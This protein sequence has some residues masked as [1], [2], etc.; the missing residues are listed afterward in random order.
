[1]PGPGKF[2]SK[3]VKQ[4]AVSGDHSPEQCSHKLNGEF[5]HFKPDKATD[6]KEKVIAIELLGTRELLVPKREPIDRP[7]ILPLSEFQR[8]KHQA[9]VITLE[10]KMRMIEEGEREKNKLVMESTLRKEQLLKT[11]KH[12]N[13]KPGSK[14]ETVESEAAKKNL[15]LLRRSQ[16]LR[17]EQDERVKEANGIILATKCRAIRNAQIAEKKVIEKELKEEEQRLDAMMEQQRQKKIVAEEKKREADEMKKQNYVKEVLQ[18]IKENELDRLLEAE[19]IEEESKM[20][21]KALIELQKDE[22]K[23]QKAKIE[24]QIKMREEFKKANEE[25]CRY[26]RLKAEEQRIADLRVKEFMRQKAER[27]EALEKEKSLLKAAKEKEIARLREMQEKSQDLQ[28]ALDEMNAARS[29]EEKEREW[30]EQEKQAALK[31][32]KMMEDLH[33]ARAKQITDIRMTQARALARD[34]DDFKK[35]AKVQHELHLKDLEKQAKKREEIARHRK[36]LLKQINEKERERINWQQ[37]RYDDGKAQRLDFVLKDK[38][39]EE[40]LKH[41]IEKLRKNNVPDN[42][43]KDIERQLRL[44]GK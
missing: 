34:E 33:V 13:N 24:M 29:Q 9:H 39:V 4:K 10:D 38:N 11:Q 20:L 18:Q 32:Q 16:E 26:R 22:E 42:Y 36:E 35:V 37:E 27:E 41:K 1:M 43:I 40:Y 28:A 21:N 2:R 25:A 23:R 6:G 19:R 15:Y 14:L 12:T 44:G 7:G 30:R 31:K 8:L 17:I 5:I 3:A